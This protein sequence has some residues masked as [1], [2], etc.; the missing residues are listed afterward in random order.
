MAQNELPASILLVTNP[1]GHSSQEM[2]EAEY[3]PVGHA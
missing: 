3:L 1:D 2:V